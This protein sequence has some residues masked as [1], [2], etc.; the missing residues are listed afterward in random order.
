MSKSDCLAKLTNSYGKITIAALDHRGSLKESLRDDE[1]L[2]W[3]RR[4]VELYRDEVAGILIDPVYGK[5]ILDKS[6]AVGWMLSMEK[7]GY[8]GDKL[9]RVTEILPNWSVKQ[10]K[11]MG[12]SG[13]KLLLYY[14]PKNIEL[15]QKQKALAQKIAEDCIKEEIVFLLEPL[16]Y[17]IEGSR[18][19]EVL[20]IA[21][22]L[23][24]LSVDIF[25]FEYPGT[26]EACEKITKI[27]K[28]P[29]VLL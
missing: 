8:R 21:D 16:S 26:R 3:K 20:K 15:A 6:L 10:A 17:K 1:I 14:D 24:D 25:M 28:V 4:M 5:D 9:A 27:I 2:S 19:V 22:E 12:A 29:W 23:K 7:T 11:E 18:E 13:V